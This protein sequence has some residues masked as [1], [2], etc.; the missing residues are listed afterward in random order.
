MSCPLQGTS[1]CRGTCC[2][3]VQRYLG[4]ISWQQLTQDAASPLRLL[5]AALS[6]QVFCCHSHNHPTSGPEQGI[7]SGRWH[8]SKSP[9]P[10]R[11]R[12]GA[13]TTEPVSIPQAAR[14]LQPG[15]VPAPS[16]LAIWGI[17][18]CAVIIKGLK[19]FSVSF[20]FTE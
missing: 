7:C 3:K 8:L 14:G 4:H 5:W 18:D 12:K 9:T 6:V 20:D 15:F 16:S 13:G 17:G 2:Y 11:A 1:W 10:W 19:P